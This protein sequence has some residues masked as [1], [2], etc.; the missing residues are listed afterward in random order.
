MGRRYLI[1]GGAGFIGSNFIRRVLDQEPDAAVT[2]LDAMTY[3]GVPATVAELDELEGHTFVKGDIRDA[4]LVDEV[5]P[6]HDVVV[7]F[8]AQANAERG[9]LRR[10]DRNIALLESLGPDATAA[11]CLAVALAIEPRRRWCRSRPTPK[12]PFCVARGNAPAN[13]KTDETTTTDQEPAP[14]SIKDRVRADYAGTR[15][16]TQERRV[17][18]S[19]RLV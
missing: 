7:H 12:P 1:T 9:E 17:G 2:N 19:D 13:S 16:T 15:W 18:V 4:D 14:P 6:G 3:A 10:L 5:V 8:A 11:Q